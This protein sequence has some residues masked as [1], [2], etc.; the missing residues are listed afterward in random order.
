MGIIFLDYQIEMWEFILPGVGR[1][2]PGEYLS[3]DGLI[4]DEEVRSAAHN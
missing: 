3:D 4:H 2:L 1:L